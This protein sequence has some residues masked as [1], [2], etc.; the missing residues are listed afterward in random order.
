MKKNDIKKKYD[1]PK[2][3]K[4]I[5]LFLGFSAFALFFFYMPKQEYNFGYNIS[6][7]LASKVFLNKISDVIIPYTPDYRCGGKVVDKYRHVQCWSKYYRKPAVLYPK[8]TAKDIP[9]INFSAPEPQVWD[10]NSDLRKKFQMILSIILFG[11]S[12]FCLWRFRD[13]LFNSLISF[14]KK[15]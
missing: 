15:I 2:I 5:Y 10:R 9:G 1:F 4:I 8:W 3:F 6:K 7:T 11:A 14:Y 13:K 12:I